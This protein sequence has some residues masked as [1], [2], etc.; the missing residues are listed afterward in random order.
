MWRDDRSLNLGYVKTKELSRKE[1]QDIQNTG[2]EDSQG[3][4][5]LDQEQVLNIWEN[6]ITDSTIEVIDQ[7]T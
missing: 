4:I 1:N 7:K 5:M 2:I 6:Y 3:S